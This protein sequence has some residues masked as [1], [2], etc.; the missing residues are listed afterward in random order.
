MAAQFARAAW[1]GAADIVERL[2][3]EKVCVD[4]EML[5]ALGHGYGQSAPEVI[6]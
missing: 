6:N 4:P 5:A 3:R 1:P 2:E